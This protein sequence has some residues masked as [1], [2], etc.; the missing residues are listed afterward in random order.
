MALRQG[1]IAMLCGLLLG[2][3]CISRTTS[4]VRRTG[5][6]LRGGADADGRVVTR[7]IIWFWEPEF[8]RR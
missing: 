7:D 8:R 1:V 5:E 4:R 6:V 3:G 2:A